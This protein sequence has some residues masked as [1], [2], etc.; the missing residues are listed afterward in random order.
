VA[1]RQEVLDADSADV[2]LLARPLDDERFGQRL[3]A[4]VVLRPGASATPDI[5]EEYVRQNLA[6]DKVPREI[7]I[8]DELPRNA[9]GKIVR[10]ELRA[11]LAEAATSRRRGVER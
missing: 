3:A 2:A 9:V 6:N 5:L 4:F 11:R 10:G 7:V 1:N 8:V